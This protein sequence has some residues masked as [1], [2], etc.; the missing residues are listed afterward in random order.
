MQ[1]QAEKIFHIIRRYNSVLA[2]IDADTKADCI[3]FCILAIL[4]NPQSDFFVQVRTAKNYIYSFLLKNINKEI[5]LEELPETG[6]T[7]SDIR[8]K[9]ILEYYTTHT[10]QETCSHFGLTPSD[11]L[12]K[13]LSEACPKPERKSGKRHAEYI[14]TSDPADAKTQVQKS[15]L[16]KRGYIYITKNPR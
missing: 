13:A 11:K 10:Y 12:R 8:T 1:N 16:K 2:E 7:E 5:M 3:Q 15:R 14:R 4:E 6:E 9:Q